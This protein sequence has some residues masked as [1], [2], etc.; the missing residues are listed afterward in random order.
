MK[1]YSSKSVQYT[2]W[3]KASATLRKGTGRKYMEDRLC[4]HQIQ[5]KQYSYY[6]F[7]LL[8]G[9]GGSDVVDF[10]VQQFCPIL[11]QKLKECGE[12]K[13][14]HVLTETFETLHQ[15][16]KA[17]NLTAGT[18]ASVLLVQQ[19]VETRQ[20]KTWVANVGD[21]TVYGIVLSEDSKKPK[22]FQKLSVDHT[23]RVK[24]ELTRIQMIP[25]YTTTTDGYV[26][27]HEGQML[28][29][30]RSIGDTDFGDVVLATPYIRNTSKTPYNLFIL[31]SDGIWDVLSCK[32]LWA[33]IG[34][35]ENEWKSSAKR[36]NDWR[37]QMYKQHDNTSL[38]LVYVD[39]SLMN[40]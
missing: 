10:V 26:V 24:K 16:V 15:Q 17:R 1:S 25:H 18:T 33:Q 4:M 3:L 28:A 14:R 8:D 19:N 35:I 27:T 40:L 31:A 2:S 9:H 22:R 23:I 21:S 5:T 12:K 29:M 20:V 6:V 30:T 37:N 32:N 7:L 38:I 34:D 36:L 13:I 39:R 11:E